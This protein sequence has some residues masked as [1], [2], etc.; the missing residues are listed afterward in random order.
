ML[1]I[2]HVALNKRFLNLFICPTNEKLVII[3][4]L[5]YVK[6]EMG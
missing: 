6:W 1:K 5:K 3:G 4:C 2:K